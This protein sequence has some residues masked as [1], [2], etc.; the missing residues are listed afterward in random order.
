MRIAITVDPEIPVPPTLYG[1]IE[2]IVDF[3][4]RGLIERGHHVTLFAHPASTVSGTLRAYPGR[5]SQNRLD[6]ARNMYHINRELLWGRYDLVHSFGRL[7]YLL[8]SLPLSLPKLMSYQRH[9]AP[10]S[11]QI[12][13]LLSGGRLHYSGCSAA[14]IKAYQQRPNWHVVYN[15]VPAERYTFQPTV[16]P[17]APLVFL[18]RVEPIKGP[19]QAITIARQT[20]RTLIIAGNIPAEHQAFFDQAIRPAIDDRQIHYL[21]PVDDR[22]KNALLGQAA[23]LLMPI[24]WEEPFGIV[25]AEALACGTP[26]VGL[27]RGAVP[28][29]V[30]HGVNGFVG[31]TITEL[32][33]AVHRVAEIDRHQCRSILEQRFSAQAIVTAYERIYHMMV[34]Q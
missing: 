26:V 34:A 31:T 27:C 30:T 3:L 5:R 4:V 11:V 13:D 10:R 18:G 17:D 33:G 2:R 20:G 25:M 1:G 8:P 23:A 29:V 7:A 22:Q 24:Q 15:G 21:G 28:E 16:A 6:L 14:L 19:E 12:G 32:V 9:I